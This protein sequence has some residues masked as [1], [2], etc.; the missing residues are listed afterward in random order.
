M[1]RIM[2]R[3]GHWAESRGKVNHYIIRTTQS[4][5]YMYTSFSQSGQ[6]SQ[7]SGTSLPRKLFLY[8][9][10]GRFAKRLP[11]WNVEG[12]G[13]YF[14]WILASSPHRLCAGTNSKKCFYPLSLSRRA[15]H[16]KTQMGLDS[17]R[18]STFDATRLC[19]GDDWLRDVKFKT[20]E[21]TEFWLLSAF[22]AGLLTSNL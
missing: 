2:N 18:L 6:I 13:I 4:I 10:V 7:H 9:A 17:I 16:L 8:S 3:S 21:M 5:Q 1:V 12:R 14:L 22:I 19:L 11:R 15:H 20:S